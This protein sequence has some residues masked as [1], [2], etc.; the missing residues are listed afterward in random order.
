M[1]SLA[2]KAQQVAQHAADT[3]RQAGSLLHA[4]LQARRQPGDEGAQDPAP[5]CLGLPLQASF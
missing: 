5:W 3:A 2:A 1:C 4:H